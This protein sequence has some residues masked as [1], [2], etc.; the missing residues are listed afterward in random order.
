MA[1]H[2]PPVPPSGHN[3]YEVPQ[4]KSVADTPDMVLNS[5]IR[6]SLMSAL[7][8][9]READITSHTVKGVVTLTGSVKTKGL[10]SRAE[11]VAGGV[12][13]VRAVRNQL[14]VK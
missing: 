5:R 6:A 12:H 14:V 3:R 10:R 8:A 13:G 4:P 9:A 7:S 2:R 11:Q 1:G